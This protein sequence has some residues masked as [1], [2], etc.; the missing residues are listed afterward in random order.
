MI[1]TITGQPG[2][3]KTLYALSFVKDRS[4]KENRAVYYSG[5]SDLKLPW[6]ELPK[7]EDWHTV[8]PGSIVVIDECQ[9]VF[10]PRGQGSLVPEHV[11][12]LETHRHAGLDLVLITQHPMLL[13]NNVRRLVGQHFHVVRTFGTKKATVHEWSEVKIECDKRRL[14]SIRHDFFY[15]AESFGWYKSAEVHTHKARIPMRVYLLLIIPVLIG[16]LAWG[17]Y[18]FLKPK[19]PVIPALSVALGVAP[20]V[21]PGRAVMN[22]AQWL[23]VRSARLPGLAYSAPVYDEVTKPV[24]A[25]FPA[26]CIATK[27]KCSCFSQQATALDVPESLCRQIVDRGFFK[28][29]ESK[30]KPEPQKVAL[31]PSIDRRPKAEDINPS[32]VTIPPPVHVPL[33]DGFGVPRPGADKGLALKPSSGSLGASPGVPLSGS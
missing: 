20:G 2:A 21:A 26:A 29:W 22:T 3:G 16:F 9:R 11:S 27:N 13:D 19:T 4:E 24:D 32:Y 30:Q 12:K 25:P 18:Q 28:E 15:P 5:I 8:P 14:D 31:A 17:V 33:S 1:T 23:D 6:I 10:R 7:G